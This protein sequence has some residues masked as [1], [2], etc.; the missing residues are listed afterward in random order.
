MT[1]IL[2]LKKEGQD[3]AT[4]GEFLLTLEDGMVGNITAAVFDGWAH[5]AKLAAAPEPKAKPSTP[6]SDKAVATIAE[7]LK[8]VRA[9]E[10]VA[11]LEAAGKRKARVERLLATKEYQKRSSFV[12][13]YLRDRAPTREAGISLAKLAAEW[14]ARGNPHYTQATWGHQTKVMAARGQINRDYIAVKNSGDS[15]SGHREVRVWAKRKDEFSCVL[16]EGVG[17]VKGS[18]S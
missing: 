4:P 17:V 12:R 6:L 8:M 10:A 1:W 18:A 13:L 15:E 11:K 3:V 2:T 5:Y 14:D 9:A 7:R 16:K